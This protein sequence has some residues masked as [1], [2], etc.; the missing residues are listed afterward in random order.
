MA[1]T[2]IPSSKATPWGAYGPGSPSD[3]CIFLTETNCS[4][5]GLIHGLKSIGVP[6]SITRD[7]KEAIQHPTVLVYPLISGRV[8]SKA[9]F[10]TLADFMREGG[11]LLAINVLGGFPDLFGVQAAEISKGHSAIV[12]NPAVMQRFGLDPLTE[13]R[14][15]IGRV[16]GGAV[17]GTY[18]YK[19]DG[20][21]VVATYENGEP[22]LVEKAVGRGKGCAIGLDVG[23]YFSVAYNNRVELQTDRYVNAFEPSIDILLRLLKRYYLE[24]NQTAV[25]IGTVPSGRSASVVMSHDIDFTGSLSNAVEYAAVEASMGVKA[26]YFLQTKYVKDYNDDIFFN[27]NGLPHLRRLQALNMEVASHSVA[28]APSF[29]GFEMGTGTEKYP[30]YLPSVQSRQTTR[31]GSLLGELRVSKFLIEHFGGRSV[32]S[33]RPGH[34]SYPERLPEALAAVGYRYSSSVTANSSLTH[35]PY[36]LNHSRGYE[37]ESSIFEF[38]VTIE[39]EEKPPLHQR[40]EQA[41]KIYQSLARYGGTMILLIHTETTGSKLEFVRRFI[42][43]TV[44]DA[45]YGTLSELGEWWSA[46]DSLTVR[47]VREGGNLTVVIATQH[48]LRGVALEVDDHWVSA[49]DGAAPLKKFRGAWIIPELKQS[50]TLTFLPQ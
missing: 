9:D 42:Q 1:A 48:P 8:L 18:A 33:F 30:Q 4:W 36:R 17:A 6:C 20:G 28:H 27:S 49:T 2:L 22:A 32:I 21:K 26:T 35:L 16:K 46:R 31:N 50:V 19:L 14:I 23:H 43:G 3:F 11:T 5:L 45:W 12:L 13:N 40:L 15:Q 25:V 7:V 44:A 29:A 24:G 39:D 38:P 41:L 34:L 37:S 10:N 47:A